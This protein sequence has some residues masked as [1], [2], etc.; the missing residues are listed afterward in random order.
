MDGK[1]LMLLIVLIVMVAIFLLCREVVCW[2][3]KINQRIDLLNEIADIL[4]KGE[5]TTKNK[6]GID[7]RKLKGP[8][9]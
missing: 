1:P 4:A 6:F 9:N 5:R 8:V 7:P 3:F 2:Y